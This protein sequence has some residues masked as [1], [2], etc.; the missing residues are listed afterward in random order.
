MQIFQ[1]G[2]EQNM[3]QDFKCCLMSPVLRMNE[4]KMKCVQWLYQQ[5]QEHI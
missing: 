2:I 3:Q 4:S 1:Q 5:E